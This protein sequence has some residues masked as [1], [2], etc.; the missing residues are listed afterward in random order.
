MWVI[1]KWPRFQTGESLIPLEKLTMAMF[2]LSLKSLGT[3]GMWDWNI[4]LL[5]T[6]RLDSSGSK[7]WGCKENFKLIYIHIM[8]NLYLINALFFYQSFSFIT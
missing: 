2:S 7:I 5:R 4:S 6:P 1:F 3:M 8:S